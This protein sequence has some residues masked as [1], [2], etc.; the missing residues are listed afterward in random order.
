MAQNDGRSGADAPSGSQASPGAADASPPS[1]SIPNALQTVF[2]VAADEFGRMRRENER[3][4]QYLATIH[5]NAL[6]A[7]KDT[8]AVFV[9][10]VVHFLTGNIADGTPAHEAMAAFN[11]AQKCSSCG[12][13]SPVLGN[14]LCME[15]ALEWP[16]SASGIA[17]RSDE[18]P[19]A[20]QPEGQEPGPKGDAQP[21]S[22]SKD[23]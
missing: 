1:V 12:A 2:D 22:S 9:S 8:R 13:F 20:A 7:N 6:R 16:Q 18:T 19:Q 15:C 10:F 11:A 14:G 21:Q 5:V 17:A 23:T 3:L 4:R